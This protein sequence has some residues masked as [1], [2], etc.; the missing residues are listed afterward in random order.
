MRLSIINLIGGIILAGLTVTPAIADNANN[1]SALPGTVNYVEGNVDLGNQ[2]LNAK[3]VGSTTLEPGQSLVTNQGKA[4]LLL[5]PGVFVRLADNSAVELVNPSLTK[6]EVR[7]DRGTAMVEVDEIH[8][9]NNLLVADNGATTRL[10][11]TG[12]YEFDADHGNVFVFKGKAEVNEGDV[13]K[14]LKGGHEMNLTAANLKETGFN[15]KQYENSDLYQFSSLR[16]QYIGEAS[17]D[18][19]Q[20]YMGSPWMPGWWWDP[21]FSAYTFFP[22]DGF[23]YSPFGWGWGFYSPA[24]IGYYG[25]PFGYGGFYHHGYVA[26]A[27]YGNVKSI[28]YHNHVSSFARTTGGAGHLGFRGGSTGFHGGSSGFHGGGMSMGGFH[29]GGF[30]GGGGFRH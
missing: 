18:A 22:G 1:N 29:G 15:K 28:P 4:E 30:G 5:T 24:W 26:G 12:L 20:D 10:Q 25:V 23:L 8:K 11:K 13:H 17:V 14:E 19:A 6:T 21:W 16:S 27:R 3:S 7:L 9:E 2:A